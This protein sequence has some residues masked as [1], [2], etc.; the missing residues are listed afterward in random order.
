M[1]TFST[2]LIFNQHA[3]ASHIHVFLNN[4]RCVYIMIDAS[5]ISV[6]IVQ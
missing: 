3:H 4:D 2:L 5:P 1:K 6:E